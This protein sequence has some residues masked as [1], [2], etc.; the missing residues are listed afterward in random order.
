MS[1]Y[2]ALARRALYRPRR[3]L[4]GP[5]AFFPWPRAP[6][7]LQCQYSTHGQNRVMFNGNGGYIPRGIARLQGVCPG[8]TAGLSLRQAGPLPP[9]TEGGKG[10]TGA[11]GVNLSACLVGVVQAWPGGY[12]EISALPLGMT[13]KLFLWNNPARSGRKHQRGSRPFA[14]ARHNGLPSTLSPVRGPISRGH[15]K[16]PESVCS[17]ALIPICARG[18][19]PL[20][21]IPVIRGS[22]SDRRRRCR[23]RRRR[24]MR[25][26]RG[27]WRRRCYVRRSRG[28]LLGR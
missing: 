20:L 12:K 8:V 11:D 10:F 28:F 9:S 14:S 24:Y 4:W 21:V 18:A 1:F 5:A 19:F 15:A 22:C 2:D 17:P 23:R 7:F 26:G 16:G 27:G 13:G 6:F 25:R 3:L